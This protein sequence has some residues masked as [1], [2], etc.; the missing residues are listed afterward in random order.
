MS[1]GL[2]PAIRAAVLMVRV[3]VLDVRPGKRSGGFR[4]RCSGTLIFECFSGKVAASGDV[5]N[6]TACSEVS[7]AYARE[8]AAASGDM[9]EFGLVILEL[10]SSRRTHL[11]SKYWRE[12]SARL[13]DG[14]L[15]S[16][17]R[18]CEGSIPPLPV[19]IVRSKRRQ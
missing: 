9:F 1:I 5:D 3:D 17:A 18:L 15:E 8:A 2:P 14:S 4:E 19:S 7:S 6:C 10:C 16:S 12:I 13:A 11:L